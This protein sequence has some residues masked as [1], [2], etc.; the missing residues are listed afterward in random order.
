MEPSCPSQEP[1][2]GQSDDTTNYV[3]LLIS[4]LIGICA[5]VFFAVIFLRMYR[6]IMTPDKG[7]GND[8]NSTCKEASLFYYIVGGVGAFDSVRPIWTR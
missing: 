3:A 8:I 7:I 1:N 2:E 6:R 4:V 5:A